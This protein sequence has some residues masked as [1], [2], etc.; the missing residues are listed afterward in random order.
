MKFRKQ[1]KTITSP[2]SIAKEIQKSEG[3]TR[4]ILSGENNSHKK[5][6]IQYLIDRL[7]SFVDD[8]KKVREMI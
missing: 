5:A 2:Q 1:L 3:Y 4:Q 8:L 6:I 7:W